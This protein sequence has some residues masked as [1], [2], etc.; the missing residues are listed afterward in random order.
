MPKDKSFKQVNSG[1]LVVV[2]G[3]R[4]GRDGIHGATFSSEELHKDSPTQAVQIGDPITQKK[5]SDFIYEARDKSLY[6]FVTD[7]GAG[8]LSSSIGEMAGLCGGCRIDVKKA[9]LK[10]AGL[11]PWEII[12]SEAQER[13]VLAVSPDK[14]DELIS[15]FEKEDVEVTVIG[16]FTGTKHLRLFYHAQCVTD[17]DVDFLHN[18]GP[19]LI[20]KAVWEEPKHKERA[21]SKKIDFSGDLISLLSN[22][23]PGLLF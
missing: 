8:G 19:D 22:P 2:V 3:G 14:I 13:M 23:I 16:R 1:D 7:N 6:R 20:R 18:G 4:T 17:L 21:R 12:L 5:M 10:Y 9:P 15:I 11:Q